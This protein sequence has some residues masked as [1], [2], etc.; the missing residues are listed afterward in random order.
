MLLYAHQYDF[1][2]TFYVM[3]WPFWF[4]NIFMWFSICSIIFLLVTVNFFVN[5]VNSFVAIFF[6]YFFVFFKHISIST[7]NGFS[8][9]LSLLQVTFSN[10]NEPLFCNLSLFYSKYLVRFLKHFSFSFTMF[11]FLIYT[12][13]CNH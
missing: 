8:L 3:H 9:L 4:S 1:L 12:L 5:T 6:Q 7:S 10:I 11:L 13:L 2:E